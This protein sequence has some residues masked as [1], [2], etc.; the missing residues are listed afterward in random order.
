MSPK[1]IMRLLDDVRIYNYALPATDIAQLYYDATGTPACVSK[2]AG[3]IDDDCDVDLNDLAQL[4]A[5]WLDCG[6]FPVCP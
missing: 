4:S 3:D 2:P 1:K 5:D 6:L